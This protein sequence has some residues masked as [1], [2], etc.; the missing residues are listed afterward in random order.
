MTSTIEE[1]ELLARR[2]PLEGTFNVRDIGGYATL[3]GRRTAWRVLLRG[4]ALHRV[5]DEGRELLRDYGI[6]TSLDL[7]E[8]DERSTAPD[9]LHDEV[10][11]V[12]IPLFTYSPPEP[13]DFAV[14]TIDRGALTNLADAYRA[15][16][17]QR[18]TVLVA[19]IRELL[20]PGALPAVVHCTAG[21]DR[22]GVLIALMLSSIGVADEVI[23]ADYAA[24]SLFLTEEFLEA[25]ATRSL[26]AGYDTA[27]LKAMLGCEPELILDVL[28][29]IRHTYGGVTAFL[30]QHGMTGEELARLRGL[31]LEP[32]SDAPTTGVTTT[33]AQE[34]TDD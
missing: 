24:T 33:G 19:A 2:V 12:S 14:G 34:G 7:R 21:K 16:V 23:A 1:A 4:D 13:E 9:R 29:E 30:S 11:L 32:E 17:L 31:L 8:D 10:V 6:R 3:D 28:E 15:L 5:D 27:R 18:G 26:A 20:R 25:A 22:T